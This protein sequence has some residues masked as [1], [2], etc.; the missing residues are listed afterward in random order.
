MG[1][2]VARVLLDRQGVEVAGACD[3]RP[4][5]AGADLGRVIGLEDELGVPVE[6]DLETA[7]RTTRPDVTIQT[8]CSELDAVWPD[9]ALMLGNGVNVISIAEEMTYPWCRSE[10]I[11]REMHELAV[12]NGAVV[13]GTGVNPGFVFDLLI[14][15]LTGVCAEVESIEASRTNDLSPY[16]ATVLSAQ[17]VGST[18]E[19]FVRGVRQGTIKGHVG[20]PQS[21]HLI[22]A[23][24][25]WRIDRI[26]QKLDPIV[27][28]VRRETLHTV[29]EPG[30]VAGCLHSAVAYRD[31][32]P[33]ITLTH[34]QQVCPALEG[35]QTTDRIDIRGTP[36]VHFEGQPEIAGGQATAALAVNMISRVLGAA[37]GLHTMADLPVPAALHDDVRHHVRSIA[38]RTG[39]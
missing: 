34:P 20:F 39:D 15:T 18:P 9:I 12:A 27:S 10:P 31:G 17:G 35:L 13:L 28:S 19:A 29:V 26:E 21:M 23:T 22:A 2:E 1:C 30:Q 5:L 16:G 32:T 6:S 37:P 24:L 38:E 36:P 33:A 8:T 11:A 14:L 4:G 3:R 7:V 25:G